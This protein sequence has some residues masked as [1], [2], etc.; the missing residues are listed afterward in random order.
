MALEVTEINRA[1]LLEKGG[2]TI[3]LDDPSSG[4]TVDEVR[5][6][7]SGKYPELTNATISGPK[8][9]GGKANYSFKTTAGTKG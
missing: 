4:M 8:V 7:Y 2:K 6:H 1:F 9:E 3:T 5:K